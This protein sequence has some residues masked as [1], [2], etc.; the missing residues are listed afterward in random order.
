M[1]VFPAIDIMDGQCVRLVKGDPNQKTVYGN[2]LEKALE[3]KKAGAEFLHI[4]DLNAAFDN[5]DNSNFDVI[6]DI[7]QTVNIPV[8]IGGGIRSFDD[9]AYRLEVLKA[10]RVIL[11]TIAY[12]SSEILKD[13]VKK[14]GPKIVVGMDAKDGFLAVKGWQEITKKNIIDMGK[15]LK[16]L[17]VHTVLFTD[18]SRDGNL[19]G[20]NIQK[21]IE[22]QNQCGLN[23]IASGG[24]KDMD[25]VNRLCEAG[26][27]GVILGKSLY[28]NKINLVEAINRSKSC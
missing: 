19:Q 2:P 20:I 16:D 14:Y 25:D 21:T 24:A 18:I 22:I 5:N 17:G 6:K 23:V 27:Y 9:I 10:Y 1:I 3:F 7:I 12:T 15:E 8:Q 4:V 28:E 13:A 11:G 26:V